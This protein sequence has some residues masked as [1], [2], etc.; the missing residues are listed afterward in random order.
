MLDYGCGPGYL[1]DCLSAARPLLTGADINEFYL[2]GC[3][4]KHPGSLFVKID[5]NPDSNATI[6]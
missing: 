2:T 1:A 6:F 4:R 3:R 5:T